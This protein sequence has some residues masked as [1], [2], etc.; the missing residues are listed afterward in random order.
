MQGFLIP[1]FPYL[2]VRV[3]G[4]EAPFFR[5]AMHDIVVP[6]L[7]G[8]AYRPYRGASFAGQPMDFL[9]IGGCYYLYRSY[10]FSN[11]ELF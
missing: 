3:D 4:K 10:S 2:D 9:L 1:C 5:S 6:V 11:P 8:G 7:L